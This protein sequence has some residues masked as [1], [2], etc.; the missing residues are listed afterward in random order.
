M[1]GQS[2]CVHQ[3]GRV[4][5]GSNR[6]PAA[7]GAGLAGHLPSAGFPAESVAQQYSY[8]FQQGAFCGG[9]TCKTAFAVGKG[10]KGQEAGPSAPEA[11]AKQMQVGGMPG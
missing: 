7:V 1:C 5:V 2:T 10:A 6:V 4:W 11:L 3:H 8:W 9:R